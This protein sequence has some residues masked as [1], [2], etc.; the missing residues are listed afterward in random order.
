MSSIIHCGPYLKVKPILTQEDRLSTNAY[1]L[2]KLCSTYDKVSGDN[3]C[4]ICG[5]K[6]TKKIITKPSY[7]NY[8][9]L[10]GEQ[11]IALNI[12]IDEYKYLIPNITD[13][14]TNKV[15]TSFEIFVHE[16]SESEAQKQM[17]EFEIYFKKEIEIIGQHSSFIA[18]RYGMIQFD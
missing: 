9:E 13:W 11:L 17:N 6:L 3:Y 10:I 7:P 18:I 1:C 8:Y 15:D 5:T 14:S 12:N 2:N 4:S 16:F